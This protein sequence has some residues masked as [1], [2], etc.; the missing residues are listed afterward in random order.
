MG[1]TNHGSDRRPGIEPPVSLGAERVRHPGGIQDHLARK[2]AECGGRTGAALEL[3]VELGNAL[4]RPMEG[5]T[6]ELWDCLA[7]I[8]A[9]NLTVA[10][11]VE[12]H[13]D[14][15]A[16]LAQSPATG[17]A[18]SGAV[19]DGSTWGVF[20]AE[21][22]EHNLVA[23]R[24]GNA[25]TLHGRKPWCSLAGRLSHAVVTAHT[26]SGRR[27]FLVELGSPGVVVSAGQWGALG[28]ADV[29]SSP[30]Q[31]DSVPAV[32]L[33]PAGWYFSRPGFAWGGVGVAAIWFGAATAI[34]RRIYAH[35][36]SRDPDQIALMH[37]GQTDVALASARNALVL[38]ADIADGAGGGSGQVLAAA[39]ARAAVVRAAEEIQTIAAH[40][41]GPAPLAFDKEYATRTADLQLYLR[42]DHAE[43][44]LADIGRRL[45]Q[46]GAR[47]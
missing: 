33:G 12:P 14:A 29:D 5:R 11:V 1:T 16:I 19:P 27:A 26:D 34:A 39:R 13:L 9:G 28:L 24:G 36:L 31:F 3:A 20:A 10:R 32:P 47:W 4:P 40:A 18:H 23:R 45:I 35:S 6:L 15:V 41:M 42:Q 17:T 44:S 37:L 38:A 43:R 25:W 8:G 30:V 46:D 2:V 22:R 7:T 21:A